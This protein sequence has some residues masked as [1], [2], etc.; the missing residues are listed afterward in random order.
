MSSGLSSTSA[1]VCAER[2]QGDHCKAPEAVV[3]SGSAEKP[4]WIFQRRPLDVHGVHISGRQG[5]DHLMSGNA[6]I[7]THLSSTLPSGL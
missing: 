3:K 2:R 7:C 5:D 4:F 6:T 1:R